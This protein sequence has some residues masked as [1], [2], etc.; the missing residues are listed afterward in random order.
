MR[1][2]AQYPYS[3]FDNTIKYISLFITHPYVNFSDYFEDVSS[4]K[5]K[6]A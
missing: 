3:K 6:E 5:T 1:I 4:N 2:T